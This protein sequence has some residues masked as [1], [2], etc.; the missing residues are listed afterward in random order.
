MSHEANSF[1]TNY[2]TS[3]KYH[4]Q[5]YTNN[6]YNYQT[7]NARQFTSEWIVVPS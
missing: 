5:I 7:L 3:D 4:Q 1:E 6:K 2:S